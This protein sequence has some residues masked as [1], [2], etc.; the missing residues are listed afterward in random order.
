MVVDHHVPSVSP[1]QP[2]VADPR[3]LRIVG[4]GRSGSTVIGT[5]LGQLPA[6]IF[7]GEIT[8]V[9]RAFTTPRW[10]CSCGDLVASCPFWRAVRSRSQ[11]DT[12]FD[13]TRLRDTTERYLR[14][15]P[16]QLANLVRP[17]LTRP[18]VEYAEALERVYRAIA[19]TAGAGLIV[20]STKSAPEL[21][22]A[23]RTFRIRL[24]VLH[25]VRDPR[26]VAH[27]Q[28][29]PM[30]ATMQPGYD[31]A[32]ERASTSSARWTVRNGL[33]GLILTQHKAAHRRI[34]Y[35]D[36]ISSPAQELISLHEFGD[37]ASIAAHLTQTNGELS[38]GPR[39]ALDGNGRVLQKTS[40]IRLRLDEEWRSRMP[41]PRQL[42]A[43]IPAFPLMRLYGYRARTGSR[44]GCPSR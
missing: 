43:S 25:V 17:R 26:A 28:N 16:L 23:V 22:L 40:T 3:I 2:T 7:L 44:V 1:M 6:A 27:S 4:D 9:W 18:L 29:R 14:I 32:P 42:A 5:V 41:F 38:V 19:A 36:F 11:I 31:W 34:R 33:L 8:Q 21:L 30:P 35:E 39:H 24:D 12:A 37:M 20:D 10:R 15:R 13:V